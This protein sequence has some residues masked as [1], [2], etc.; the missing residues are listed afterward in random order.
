M[1]DCRVSQGISYRVKQH[2]DRAVFVRCSQREADAA[3]DARRA[4]GIQREDRL[5]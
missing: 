4:R 3:G 5:E 1:A 2:L